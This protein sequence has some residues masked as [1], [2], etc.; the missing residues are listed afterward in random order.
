MRGA[1]ITFEGPEGCGKTTQIR[2]IA[3][4]LRA[5]HGVEL[6]CTRE[7]GGTAVGEQ[8][9]NLLQH[10]TAGETLS[11]AAELLLFN[12]SRAQLV[13]EVI[14]PALERGAWVLCDRFYDSTLAYQGYARGLPLK[15]LREMIE[16]AV[17]RQHPDLT[18]LLDIAPEIS[19][20]RQQQRGARADRFERLEADFHRK[21]RE[22]YLELARLEPQ[23]IRCLDAAGPE[24]EVGLQIQQQL[25]RFINA[26]GAA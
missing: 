26:R 6:L 11:E 13:A 17:Q 25:E 1:L 21:V 8:I 16:F 7:P 15:P 4:W 22:G 18:L 3:D 2:R 10:D 20:A 24:E 5:E 12:A 19:A 23:R 9:R 14:R